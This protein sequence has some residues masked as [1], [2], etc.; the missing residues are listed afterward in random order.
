M[1]KAQF[2]SHLQP[3]LEA[4]LRAGN[5]HPFS[6]PHIADWP[7]TGS[8]FCALAEKLRTR[9]YEGVPEVE[10]QICT[11]PHYGWHDELFCC[12]CGDMLVAGE[13]QLPKV[14]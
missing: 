9:S 5:R 14:R 10:H 1:T 12:A 7:K 8:V 4:E 3:V 2:C 6:P 11:D 13:T